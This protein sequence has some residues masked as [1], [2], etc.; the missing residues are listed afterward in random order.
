MKATKARP[1]FVMVCT[2]DRAPGEK[3]ACGAR[4]REL[5]LGIQFHL[6]KSEDWDEI[7]AVPCGCLGLC[8][9]RPLALDPSTGVIY[10]DVE[11][12][13]VRQVVQQIRETH[14][15]ETGWTSRA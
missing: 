14:A 7:V 6:D 12:E 3:P 15:Q 10:C 8:E 5:F 13:E 9:E 11:P 1:R 2:A 4:G